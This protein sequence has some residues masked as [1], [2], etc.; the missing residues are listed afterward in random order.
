MFVTVALDS[1]VSIH[2]YAELL[3]YLKVS[4]ND[5]EILQSHTTDQ[6]TVPWVKDTYY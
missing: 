6:P 1:D 5:K 4:Q 2:E 3:I